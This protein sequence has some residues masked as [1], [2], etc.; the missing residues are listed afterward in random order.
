MKKPPSGGTASS[1]T[2]VQI[3]WTVYSNSSSTSASRPDHL[4]ARQ[5]RM[6][7]V[8]PQAALLHFRTVALATASLQQRADLLFKI[9]RFLTIGRCGKI[10]EHQ[11]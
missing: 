4:A 8:Q 7:G 2:D 6:P 9:D 5:R 10:A 1:S 11:Q 3:S